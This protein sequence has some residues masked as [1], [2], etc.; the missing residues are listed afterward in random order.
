MDDEH[1]AISTGSLFSL[2]WKPY[3]SN[4]NELISSIIPLITMPALVLTQSQDKIQYFKG[5]LTGDNHAVRI[6]VGHGGTGKTA[7]LHAALSE[8]ASQPR[9]LNQLCVLNPCEVA[10][11]LPV[12]GST[13]DEAP[14]LV[15][16]RWTHDELVERLLADF[17]EDERKMVVFEKDV[18]RG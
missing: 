14:I 7:S 15:F 2:Y 11:Y 1:V 10:P 5:I 3:I 8:L 6:I 16:I 12:T 17:D 13:H 9:I 18:N 4:K